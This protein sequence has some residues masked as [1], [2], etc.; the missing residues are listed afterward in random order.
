MLN[1]I[2]YMNICEPVISSNK[3]LAY[4]I[5][6]EGLFLLKGHLK[7]EERKVNKIGDILWISN[8]QIPPFYGQVAHFV[9][10]ENVGISTP[11]LYKI[12]ESSGLGQQILCKIWS[13]CNQVTTRKYYNL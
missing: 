4:L 2:C 7:T 5:L 1:I 13:L 3:Y 10:L 11:L 6:Y 12:L 8:G 9:T